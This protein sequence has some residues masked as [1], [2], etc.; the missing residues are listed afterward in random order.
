[1]EHTIP[2]IALGREKD[3]ILPNES[4]IDER[5]F[6]SK[7]ELED[8]IYS[9]GN[10]LS[11]EGRYNSEAQDKSDEE[12]RKAY[13]NSALPF[14]KS[15]DPS[16]VNRQFIIDCNNATKKWLKNTFFKDFL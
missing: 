3:K 11:L 14:V 4:L 8:F 1:M 10:S 7:E 6:K 16:K 9:Y 2:Q 12:K 13:R 5:G 15:F